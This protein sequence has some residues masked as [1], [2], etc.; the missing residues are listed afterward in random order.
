MGKLSSGLRINRAGDDPAGLAMSERLRAQY[1]NTS[2]AASNVEN[3][4]NYLQTADAWLQKIHDMMGRMSELA[5][6]AND[7]TKSQVDRDN[8]QKEF[9]QMQKEIARITSGATAAGK[10]N[11]MYLF[12]GGN[13]VPI[14]ESDMVEGSTESSFSVRRVSG[15]A[16][17]NDSYQAEYDY[18]ARQWTL[19]DM[20]TNTVLG[21][22]NANPREGGSM[23]FSQGGSL[24]ELTLN[25]PHI[26]G[27]QPHAKINFTQSDLQPPTATEV[28]FSNAPTQG[29]A[30]LSV[31]GSGADI[32]NARWRLSY[33]GSEWELYNLTTGTLERT[34]P[35]AANAPFGIVGVEGFDGFNIQVDR[36]GNGTCYTA[37]DRFEW[38]NQNGSVGTPTFYDTIDNSNTATI[39]I[40]GDG[41]NISSTNYEARYDGVNQRWQIYNSDTGSLIT[42]ISSDPFSGASAN[43]EG[44]NGFRL[45][46]DPP[47]SGGYSTGDTFS[48]SNEGTGG[49]YSLNNTVKLQVGPD[50]NQ[51]FTEEQINLETTNFDII[52]SYVDYSYGSV[53]MTLLG[54]TL[55]TVG[56]GSLIS[57]QDLSI[58]QQS[59]AQSA[60]SKLNIGVDHISSIRAVVGAEMKRMEQTLS[61]LRNY[62]ENSR[63]TESRIRDVDVAY[64]TTQY[65]KFQILVQIGT[66]MLAQANALPQG[67]LQMLG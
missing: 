41:M 4:I 22:F 1:R 62:E 3:K 10:F 17:L 35:A 43:L 9:E 7:G 66:A 16:V 24:F 21:Q 59:A 6:M 44:A 18:S 49:D 5:V 2:K 46:I 38:V 56:W 13:G 20:T 67:V 25:A 39:S 52:G 12:R 63:S 58:S 40:R 42:N 47:N 48:W 26:G 11:G 27:Y 32:E 36:P 29:S 23:L 34:R 51:V 64:E 28:D 60:V 54:S 45:T 65:S 61:G 31:S 53:N 50:S 14:M 57:G 19:R 33:T 37:G 55:H 30:S 15:S 8:L